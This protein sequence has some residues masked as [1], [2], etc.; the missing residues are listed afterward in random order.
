MRGS[1]PRGEPRR[2]AITEAALELFVERGFRAV[3]VDDVARA[4]GASKAT[5]ARFYGG[6]QGLLTAALELEMDLVFA[7]VEGARDL[8]AFAEALHAVVFSPRCLQLLRFVVGETPSTPELGE[9][10]RGVVLPRIARAAAPLVARARG[11]EVDDASTP[12]AVDELLGDLLGTALLEAMTGGD[13]APERLARLRR[14]AL[15]SG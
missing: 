3:T 4:A 12:V 1:A 6:R 14:R 8:P 10:F 11:T 7:P 5:I 15:A 13:P 9:T 2:A